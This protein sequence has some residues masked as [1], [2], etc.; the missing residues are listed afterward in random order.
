MRCRSKN[1]KKLRVVAPPVITRPDTLPLLDSQISWDR[2]ERFIRHLIR[3][4]PGVRDVKRYGKAGSKQK[5]ID[6]IATLEN[7][8]RWVFQCK[9]YSKY[10]LDDAKK[11]V[12]KAD[13]P[14]KKYF[15]VIACQT[16]ST[17]H[18]YIEG[19]KDWELWD[20]ERVSDE[21][22][23]L[24]RDAARD[25]VSRFFG[26]YVCKAFLGIGP[27]S[28]F[29][30]WKL[31][32]ARWLK[33]DRLFNHT[34]QLV[35]RTELVSALDQFCQD[36][37]K[38][39]ALLVG[40]GGIGKT[41]L[42]HAFAEAFSSKHPNRMLR[43]VEEN[44][45]LT[46]EA[47]SE[48]P[49]TSC[50]IVVDDAH[51]A[52]NLGPLF[53]AS[54]QPGSKKK[55]L[56]STRP[57][58]LDFL[59]AE[60][61]RAGFDY[62]ELCEVPPLK[63]LSREDVKALARQALGPKFA[64]LDR[65]LAEAT[66]D[67][68]LVTVVGGKL[69]A[70][71]AIDP[72][73]LEGHN[74]FR[75][76]VLN[77]FQDIIVG[78]IADGRDPQFY[79]DLL[80]VLSATAPFSLERNEFV[81][82]AADFLQRKPEDVIK[83]IGELE[84]IGVLLRR[85]R[86]LRVTP[87]VLADHILHR[88]CIAANGQ[89]TGYA[90]RVFAT[91]ASVQPERVFLNLAE[92]DWRV[93][94]SAKIPPLL[95]AIWKELEEVLVTGQP[96]KKAWVIG[97]T[98][99]VAYY[100]PEQAL[101]MV[102]LGLK[103]LPAATGRKPGFFEVSWRDHILRSLPDILRRCAYTLE[104]LPKA[105]C[106]LWKLGKGDQRQL[107]Q[108][109]EHAF[110]LL[111]ELAAYSRDKPLSYYEALLDTVISWL[112]EPGIHSHPN[113]VMDVLDKFLA[114]VGE[115]TWSEGDQITWS[116]FP[117]SREKTAHLRRKAFDTICSCVQT[118]DPKVILRV[119][120]S[121]ESVLHSGLRLELGKG[122][123]Q[124]VRQ[125]E[126]DQL[127]AI[128]V[129]AR[130]IK[131]ADGPVISYR[132]LSVLRDRAHPEK[133][134][135]VRLAAKKAAALVPNTFELRLV[136]A[137]ARN[138]TPSWRKR[139]KDFDVAYKMHEEELKCFHS[140]V[141]AELR[142][143]YPSG[144][145]GLSLLV[146]LLDQLRTTDIPLYESP[147]LIVLAESDAAYA[148]ELCAAIV[149]QP[150]S[151]LS[152]AFNIFLS[153]VEASQPASA[154]ELVRRAV[155]AGSPSLCCFVASHLDW[156]AR[157]RSLT[158]D[159]LL[160]L[161]V[162]LS[163]KERVVVNN[164]LGVIRWIGAKDPSAGMKLLLGVRWE[165]DTRLAS[166]ALSCIDAQHGIPPAK[167]RDRDVN[168]LLRRLEVTPD[169]G[170]WQIS[171]FVGHASGRSPLGVVS[172]LINRIKRSIKNKRS[173][174]DARPI[175]FEFHH[176]LPDLSKCPRGVGLL[177][178]VRDMTL[179][180]AWQYSHFARDIY[181]SLAP[182]SVCLELLKEWIRTGGERT[183]VGALALLETHE[184]DFVF[185]Q[186]DFVEFVF[187][188]AQK[189]GAECFDRAKSALHFCAT[190][191]GESRTIGQPGP[192]TVA[193]KE[194]ATEVAKKFAAGSMMAVFYEGIARHSEARLAAERLEDE[195]RFEND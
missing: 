75:A 35:G 85:G 172:L 179:K 126:P 84:R 92:L 5:G 189:R 94:V 55:L 157:K 142:T 188:H 117:V 105:A 131:N 139:H 49:E 68:P 102:E 151:S 107:N 39:V 2:F 195:D 154:L 66:W 158:E 9:Q 127:D 8:D 159:E 190:R 124:D 118:R 149:L 21:I 91:F 167:I 71:E 111:T 120:K 6:L 10:K 180:R 147:F 121:L 132:C 3:L 17:V 93:Q 74:G 13:Y 176:P 123:R 125:W 174:F 146:D 81:K 171:E 186:P 138:D 97:L 184:S 11:A 82:A 122:S 175:P 160:L 62:T 96:E 168:L 178:K 73:L 134:R 31:F 185:S 135:T 32:F 86:R 67:C 44:L 23:K 34:W 30:P 83:G 1:L 99:E 40:R 18:D 181:W 24:P 69:L 182:Q 53:A 153:A 58:R 33:Q 183:F 137:I 25:V 70:S 59:K 90:E 37:T 65:R 95:S 113:S 170:D 51:R 136:Q 56:L 115:D 187:N 114:K 104:S 77:R 108:H 80:Q 20:V 48:L 47:V 144:A 19:Q 165:N 15:L 161:R 42:L 45:P 43:F 145:A 29:L 26:P 76:E 163:H 156:M 191:H 162:L 128:K 141:S 133:S 57:Q 152:G 129:V 12:A 89:P 61:T 143:L 14:A 7:G 36:E 150:T 79:A 16:D 28:P 100:Q 130:I 192:A 27:T 110:R 72:K 116:R 173:D 41:K 155:K 140:Q 193:T 112:R 119:L 148:A 54:V 87:D 46:E 103:H 4:Q 52:E 63:H 177:R 22:L 194:R 164:A 50:M 106:Y 109:P 64:H 101:R 169:I 38:R 88:A 98:K 60:L 78:R 166:S